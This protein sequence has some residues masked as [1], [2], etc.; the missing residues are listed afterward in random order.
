M[1][2]K[3]IILGVTGG[4]AVYKSL[5]LVRRF[6][7]ANNEVKVVMTKSATEFVTPLSFETLSGNPVYSKLFGEIQSWEME[8]ITMASWGDVLL[9]APATA[10]IIG[11]YANGISDDALS[12]LLLSFKRQVFIAPAMNENM[13]LNPVVQDNIVRLKKRGVKF[14]EPG[15]GALACGVE[16]VGRLADLDVIESA[17][18]E[19]FKEKEDL[20][21]IKI[22]INA[23][24]TREFIDPT[25][26]ISNPSSGKMGYALAEKA[27]SRGADVVLV[28]GPTNLIAP[29]GVKL[30][31]VVS[32]QEMLKA[33]KKYHKNS[34]IV[35]FT[36]AVS[37]FRPSSV[38]KKK[39]KKEEVPD[40]IRL[41]KNPDI[42]EELGKEK[43][44]KIHI[45]FA[46][47]TENIIDNAKKKL[48][49]KK[50]DLIVVND[51]TVKDSG[52]ESD[53][54][55]VIL[56]SKRGEIIEL[57]R[58]RKLEI[59]DVIL[60]KTMELIKKKIKPQRTQ[61]RRKEK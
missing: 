22:L 23:G 61:R 44:K 52:F 25:R 56:I 17:L 60:D 37:D 15:R 51:V 30:K 59:A 26:F 38:G 13:Y 1:K 14:I 4:I 33:M 58:M 47:E 53:E 18:D 46:A 19:Y 5:E 54:N 40:S 43:R 12:T 34:D 48:N 27:V 42:A 3:K 11:K 20:R 28:S 45:G 7:K 57:G 16:G 32:A 29:D 41:S 35:I 9:I 50:F 2:V 8:H 31:K 6:K 39:I 21:G 10:N 24:P 36:A 55:I 49:K